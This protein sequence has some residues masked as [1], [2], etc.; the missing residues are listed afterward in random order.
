[1]VW[2]FILFLILLSPFPDF[3]FRCGDVLHGPTSSYVIQ[4]FLGQGSFGKVVKCLKTAT[5]ELV[6][7]KIIEDD[8]IQTHGAMQEVKLGKVKYY[9]FLLYCFFF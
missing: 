3:G 7:V 6:A 2:L 9:S 4:S 5:E 1:M 8:P